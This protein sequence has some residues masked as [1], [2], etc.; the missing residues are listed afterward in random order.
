MTLRMFLNLEK[1][2]DCVWGEFGF[3]K[4]MGSIGKDAKN[5]QVW[6]AMHW[7]IIRK[8]I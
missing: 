1:I 4:G 7:M 3:P 6:H 5:S 8:R 2:G